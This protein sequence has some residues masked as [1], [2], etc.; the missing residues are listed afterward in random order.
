[1]KKGSPGTPH[2]THFVYMHSAYSIYIWTVQY[3]NR[4]FNMYH[5][6][7]VDAKRI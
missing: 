1:M 3:I 4:I 6:H 7:L 2:E 5:T